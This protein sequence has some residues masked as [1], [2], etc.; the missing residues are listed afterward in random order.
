M[1]EVV[2]CSAPVMSAVRPSAALGLLQA[3]VAAR[4]L[5]VD[6]LYLNL[7]FA[8]RI[9]LDLN[10]LL[11]ERAPAHLLIGDWIFAPCLGPAPD[12]PE[13]E[14]HR[15]AVAALLD[16]RGMAQVAALRDG[17]AAAFVEA[18]AEEI[19]R[20]RPRMVGFSTMFQQTVASLAIAAA[21]K[22]ADPSVA[23]V[24]GGANCHGPM[25][26]ILLRHYP[27]IDHV[28]TGEADGGFPAFVDAFLAGDPSA[29]GGDGHLSRAGSGGGAAT[30]VHAMDALPVPDYGGYFDAL[31]DLAEADRIRPSVPFESSRGCWWG[32]KNHCTFCG[33]NAEGMVFRAKSPDRVVDELAV[34]AERHSV[35]RFAATDNIL[36]LAHVDTVMPA[37]AASRAEA[38]DRLLFY[39]IKSNMGEDQI[40]ALADA[41]V[42]QVQPGI[43]SLDDAVLKIMRKGVDAL[44]NLRVM[45][46]CREAG[47]GVI[48]SILYGFPGEP[49]EAYRA[50]AELVPAIEHLPPPNGVVRIRLDRFSPN[51]ERAAEL[52][53]RDLR[54]MPAYAALYDVPEDELADLAYFF[55]GHAPDSARD[56]D[57]AGLADAVARWRRA[58]Y[59][60]PA[61][62]H[63]TAVRVGPGL[64][65]KDTRSIAREPLTWLEAP[66]AALLDRLRDPA[67]PARAIEVLAA[68][69]P[70][71]AL[72][73][74]ARLLIARAFVVDRK[75]R[76]L[77]LAVE[78]GH[79]R[80][81]DALR[82][83][84]P[85][86]WLAPAA[87]E[88]ASGAGAAVPVHLPAGE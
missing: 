19:L 8:D 66:A 80:F 52:G 81:G 84:L 36:S 73:A 12:R 75:G 29:S 34:L 39:E 14:E 10:E 31:A 67:P 18:A 40:A 17:P 61:P 53:F 15:A 23:V 28:F 3:A 83:D 65:V 30:P 9:G 63:L 77:S 85:I 51:F 42:S 87:P 74:A 5:S 59:E 70:R 62:P 54:P 16:R 46:N 50:M 45:R 82:A 44:A 60:R 25:G 13:V 79:D 57:V 43:E 56:A 22:R 32:Q 76:W 2:L 41:G 24:F 11:A 68:D 48:W 38:P 72:E 55:E 35:R 7:L 88:A 6:S 4:G 33:L 69:H 20:R 26:A 49:P 64:L 71:E 86:G 47:M 1:P 21:V 78:G 37:L 27:Q 58:W